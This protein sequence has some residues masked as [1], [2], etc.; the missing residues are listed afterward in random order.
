[1][2]VR[3]TQASPGAM[4]PI[5]LPTRATATRVGGHNAQCTASPPP[6]PLNTLVI[7]SII[8]R[9]RVGA[10]VA[11]GPSQGTVLVLFTY[12]SSGHRVVTPRCR[13]VYD[14]S[15]PSGSASCTG[16]TMRA[17]YSR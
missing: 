15:C 16:A 13:P 10:P 7:T 14:L 4:K 8:P 9:C 17:V 11:E 1:M 2:H 6:K 12:G 5:V 3:A